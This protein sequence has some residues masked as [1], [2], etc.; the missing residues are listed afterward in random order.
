MDRYVGV[1]EHNYVFGPKTWVDGSDWKVQNCLGE[2]VPTRMNKYPN[3][4]L[5]DK[6]GPIQLR[7]MESFAIYI[8]CRR[9]HDLCGYMMYHI[10][11]YRG[12]PTKNQPARKIF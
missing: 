2:Y 1:E 10:K 12:I 4:W 5:N 8:A 9:H 7:I 11:S 6:N 3:L